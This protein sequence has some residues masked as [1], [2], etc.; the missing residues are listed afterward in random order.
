MNNTSIFIPYI[1]GYKNKIYRDIVFQKYP[2]YGMSL[3][4]SSA[5]NKLVIRQLEHNISLILDKSID[6]VKDL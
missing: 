6:F 5:I 2:Y 4:M 3:T 1:R